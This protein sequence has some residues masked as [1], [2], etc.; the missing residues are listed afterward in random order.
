MKFETNDLLSINVLPV[1]S[2]FLTVTYSMCLVWVQTP[3]L[4][5]ALLQS[6]S[7][8]KNPL[9]TAY[10]MANKTS[11]IENHDIKPQ[12][13]NHNLQISENHLSFQ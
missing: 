3:I 11:N 2:R 7:S 6:T 5:D 9:K 13:C 8:N 12:N 4:Q 1:P 10:V